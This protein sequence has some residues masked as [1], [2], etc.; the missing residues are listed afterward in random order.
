MNMPESVGALVIHRRVSLH[1]EAMAEAQRMLFACLNNT[2]APYHY[3]I[4]VIQSVC[5]HTG[6]LV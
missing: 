4:I 6:I 5:T 3:C 1:F 2:I